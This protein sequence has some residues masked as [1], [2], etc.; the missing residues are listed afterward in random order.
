MC[1]V[2]STPPLHREMKTQNKRPNQER[3]SRPCD[4]RYQI[5]HTGVPFPYR[6]GLGPY[7]YRTKYHTITIHVPGLAHFLD[8]SRVL[9]LLLFTSPP[10]ILL[11]RHLHFLS[12]FELFIE[13]FLNTALRPLLLPAPENH[14]ATVFV[15]HLLPLRSCSTP[16]IL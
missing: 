4:M 10:Q 14:T 8:I 6:N 15:P 13:G 2:R 3:C 11:H 5:H 1:S 9:S 12:I 7:W 16:T